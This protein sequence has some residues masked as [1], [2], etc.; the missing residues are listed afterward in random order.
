MTLTFDAP[1]PPATLSPPLQ[2]LWW[3]GKGGLRPGPEWERVD[4]LTPPPLTS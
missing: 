1:E 2:A 3:L 4:A